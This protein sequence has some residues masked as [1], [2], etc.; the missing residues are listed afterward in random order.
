MD[1]K[2]LLKRWALAYTEPSLFYVPWR[3]SNTMCSV[4]FQH[5]APMKNLSNR[6]YYYTGENTDNIIYSTTMFVI[7][8]SQ[9]NFYTKDGKKVKS[10]IPIINQNSIYLPKGNYYYKE[11]RSLIGCKLNYDVI[12]F[13]VKEENTTINIYHNINMIKFEYHIE[14]FDHIFE[15]VTDSYVQRWEGDR[16]YYEIG[17]MRSF[18]VEH[19]GK[20]YYMGKQ[21][22]KKPIIKID[23]IS[24]GGE[25]YSIP[26]E[27]D[28]EITRVDNDSYLSANKRDYYTEFYD[29]YITGKFEGKG[30][31][32]DI[33][34]KYSYN[35]LKYIYRYN[36]QVYDFAN[37]YA[38][39]LGSL[40]KF[41]NYY[42]VDWTYKGLSYSSDYGNQYTV[43]EEKGK[44]GIVFS[45]VSAGNKYATYTHIKFTPYKK[46]I[47][48]SLDSK[49][50]NNNHQIT[51]AGIIREEETLPTETVISNYY[52]NFYEVSMFNEIISVMA[53][54]ENITILSPILYKEKDRKISCYTAYLN[55]YQ[56]EHDEVRVMVYGNNIENK[57]ADDVYIGALIQYESRDE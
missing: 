21:F 1:K 51:T 34:E 42:D 32:S 23:N 37:D 19:L 25:K 48:Y 43:A 56:F 20:N 29:P 27:I 31:S 52:E 8:D 5:H 6:Y 33:Y 36:G 44:N 26:I 47:Y 54:L 46:A 38:S 22:Y 57:D 16:A 18:E 49:A 45:E 4:L 30:G 9:G 7:Y 3:K 39:F 35:Y 41:D 28:Y 55:N 53:N 10:D 17:I 13:S 50:S 24:F 40:T 2:E 15:E 11:M 12:P 14:I